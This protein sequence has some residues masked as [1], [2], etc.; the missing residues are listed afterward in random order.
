MNALAALDVA[1]RLARG[2]VR[3]MPARV[4]KS[5]DDRF[6]GAVFQVTRVTNDAY[7]H[8]PPPPGNG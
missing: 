7:G 2:V 6:F 3:A 1:L 8:K 4:R 5:L